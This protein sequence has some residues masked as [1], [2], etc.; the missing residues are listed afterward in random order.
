MASF[1]GCPPLF[2]W[3]SYQPARRVSSPERDFRPRGRLF[4][5]IR[6]A[7]RHRPGNSSTLS[8]RVQRIGHLARALPH[9]PRPPSPRIPH[10]PPARPLRPFR[11]RFKAPLGPAKARDVISSIRTSCGPP[12]PLYALPGASGPFPLQMRDARPA[13]PPPSPLPHTFRRRTGGRANGRWREFIYQPPAY[14]HARHTR[15]RSLR[16]HA[17]R[18][19]GTGKT[20]FH[21]RVTRT[22]A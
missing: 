19:R 14:A 2:P 16:R 4:R 3:I 9:M 18:G 5:P 12:G 11:T 8:R 21:A 13:I 7:R 10:N 15:Q 22:G 17:R 6:F 1:P 20:T